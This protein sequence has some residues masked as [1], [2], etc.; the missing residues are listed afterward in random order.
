MKSSVV[1]NNDPHFII[2]A[3]ETHCSRSEAVCFTTWKNQESTKRKEKEAGTLIWCKTVGFVCLFCLQPRSH[4]LLSE[5][6]I[7]SASV[8]PVFCIA[9]SKHKDLPKVHPGAEIP[10]LSDTATQQTDWNFANPRMNWDG[11]NEQAPTSS[12]G[13]QEATASCFFVI[14]Q[15]ALNTSHGENGPIGFILYLCHWCCQ[16]NGQATGGEAINVRECLGERSCPNTG[17]ILGTPKEATPTVGN[18]QKS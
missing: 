2:R 4:F 7:G 13:R 11:F 18:R 16:E 10:S 9:P 12:E 3:L 17:G 8:F 14:L 15:W 1:W 6:L 5:F